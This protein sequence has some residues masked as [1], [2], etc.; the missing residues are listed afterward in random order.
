MIG[1]WEE[2]RRA[3]CSSKEK[4]QCKDTEVGKHRE[5]S[6]PISAASL[7]EEKQNTCWAWKLE[8]GFLEA[9]NVR[10][11]TSGS[12]WGE[13]AQ[14]KVTSFYDLPIPLLRQ[15]A[16]RLN[17]RWIQRL[18]KILRDVERKWRAPWGR[19]LCVTTLFKLS[20]QAL[21]HRQLRGWEEVFVNHISD[22]GL[23]LIDR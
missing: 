10:P 5:S 12:I 20:S 2:T 23:I 8:A 21:N 1:R 22:N 6:N 19:F 13:W 11:Q 15:E 4:C 3:F 16:F 7:W 14:E 18:W 9:L 17:S